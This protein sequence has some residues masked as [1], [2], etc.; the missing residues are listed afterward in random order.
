ME[1]PLG[2]ELLWMVGCGNLEEGEGARVK[3]AAEVGRLQ[4]KLY[5][6]AVLSHT[7]FAYSA[8]GASRPAPPRAGAQTRRGSGT[9]TSQY[10]R[11]LAYVQYCNLASKVR[12]DRILNFA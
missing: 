12:T 9:G 4:R 1:E 3:H 11:R 8:P 2:T 10:R 5:Y 7:A 6:F